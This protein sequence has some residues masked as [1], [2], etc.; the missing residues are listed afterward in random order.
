MA[1]PTGPAPARPRQRRK[2]A[3][4]AEILAA[5]LALFAERGFSATRLDDVAERAGIAK[6]TIYRYFATKEDL[7]EAVVRDAF[8]PLLGNMTAAMAR[9]DI[10]A[11]ALVRL[12]IET[13]Y[14]EIVATPRREILRLLVAEA[15]RFPNLVAFYHRE[16]VGRARAIAAEIL[17]RGIASGEF[18]DGP[19]TRTPEVIIAP[20]I[21]AA[22]WKLV[23]DP[24]EPIDLDAIIAAHLDLVI[25]AIAA[26]PHQGGTPLVT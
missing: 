16:A 24:V 17:R 2:H 22:F 20:A 26:H 11:T 15:K 14:R 19:A 13:V 4:P 6:G 1:N 8:A 7:F 18:R 5:G 25:H 3:R 23:F 10:G 12:M 9:P 21:L